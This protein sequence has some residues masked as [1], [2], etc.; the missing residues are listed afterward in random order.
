VRLD[1]KDENVNEARAL[2]SEVL[3]TQS[4]NQA[5]QSL[6]KIL[7]KKKGSPDEAD[8]WYRLAEMY[9]RRSKSGRFFDLQLSRGSK[10]LSTFPS[11]DEKGSDCLKKA[12]MTY[13]KIER[14]CCKYAEM[15]SVLC[16]NA[17]AHQQIG[18]IKEAQKI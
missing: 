14:D 12:I 18:K 13:T 6:E 1:S 3:I 5:I 2:S 7:R 15:D 9:M 11:P 16:N 10:Q 17:F 4:E 8:L